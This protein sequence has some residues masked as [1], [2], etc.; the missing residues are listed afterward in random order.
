MWKELKRIIKDNNAIAL[1][2]SEPFTLFSN[3]ILKCLNT[4]WLWHKN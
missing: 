2:G 4:N 1:F 3:Q